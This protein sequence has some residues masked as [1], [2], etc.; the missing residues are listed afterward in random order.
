MEKQTIKKNQIEEESLTGRALRKQKKAERRAK[1]P[2]LYAILDWVL[3][4][5]IA[6]AAALIINFCIIVNS[7]VPSGSMENTIM[8]NTRMIGFRLSYLFHEPERGDIIIFHYPDDPKQIF[9]KRVIGLPGETVEVKAGIT[10]ID[11]EA[12]EE[13][14]I[15]PDY[16]K[17]TMEGK[18][19]D[20]GPFTVPEGSYFVMGDNRANSHDSRFWKNHYVSKKAIIGKAL[21]CYWPASN[22]GALK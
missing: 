16:W 11:G 6:L 22:M 1:N 14:Y 12:L 13:D 4:I 9:V 20:S 21:F 10:Y 15:N 5:V 18:A 17:G 7:T 3:V 2:K 19:Y 8:T